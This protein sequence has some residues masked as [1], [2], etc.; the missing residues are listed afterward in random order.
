MLNAY[1]LRPFQVEHDLWY[2]YSSYMTIYQSLD[3]PFAF[4]CWFSGSCDDLRA[5]IAFAW[6][7]WITLTLLLILAIAGPA[8]SGALVPFMAP[9][10]G[11]EQN[12]KGV[13]F[14]E[15]AFEY[16]T[17]GLIGRTSNSSEYVSAAEKFDEESRF[18]DDAEP[19]SSV[20]V[21]PERSLLLDDMGYPSS[22]EA[23]AST[24]MSRLVDD[25]E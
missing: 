3:Y 1:A 23:D 18:A 21:S 16:R 24:E 9:M 4:V 6:L 10:H 12:G 17:A 13:V 14:D 8:S 25:A 20:E 5:M 11:Y 19:S 22:A 2:K 7:S 15:E